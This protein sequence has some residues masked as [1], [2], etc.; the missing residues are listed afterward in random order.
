MLSRKELFWGYSA[1]VLNIGTGLI[2]LPVILHFLPPNEVGLWFVFLTLAGVSQLLEMGFQPTIARNVAYIYA[3]AQTLTSHGLQ[4]GASGPINFELLATLQA[5]SRLIYLRIALAA[6]FLLLTAGSAYIYSLLSAQ[7]P[8]R[9]V[10]TAWVIY[11]A[12]AILGFYF[13]Y[14]GGLL[15]GR[16]DQNQANQVIVVTRL[17]QLAGSMLFLLIGWGLTGLAVA[18]LLS[19]A[20]SRVLAHRLLIGAEGPRPE[21]KTVTRSDRNDMVAVL[22]HNAS[23]YGTV[24]IGAFLIGRANILIASSNLGLAESASYALAVQLLIV[25]Q[26]VA[27]VP[28]NLSVPRLNSLRATADKVGLY[29]CFSRAISVS[30]AVSAIGALLFIFLGPEL[31]AAIGSRTRLPSFVLLALMALSCALEINHGNCGNFLATSNT[32]SFVRPAVVT[33][34]LIV[35]V[36]VS[37]VDAYGITALVLSNLVCQLAYNNWKWPLEAARIFDVGFFRVVRDGT[38]EIIRSAR[39]NSSAS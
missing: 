20:I 19:T 16:G 8:W 27:S 11:A 39:L 5:A 29:Q 1:Q 33:G 12:G 24:L 28:F 31:L 7:D 23:R 10:I 37:A 22:W 4:A 9:M 3:G 13:G 14:I 35:I 30:L 17:V 2:I 15:T 38:N 21:R 34:L 6:G 36:S 32:I 25:L 18:A 26:G